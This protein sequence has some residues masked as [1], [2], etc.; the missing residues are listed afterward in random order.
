MAERGQSVRVLYDYDYTDSKGNKIS[1]KTGDECTLLKKSTEE[2]WSVLRKSEKKPIYVPANYVEALPKKSKDLPPKPAERPK[3][4]G[5]PPPTATKPKFQRP[6]IE[7]EALKMLDAALEG[8]VFDD[9]DLDAEI[10]KDDAGFTVIPPRHPGEDKPN[11]RPDHNDNEDPA[12]YDI[13]IPVVGGDDDDDINIPAPD[14]DDD[15]PPT[16]K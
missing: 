6:S 8:E 13:P 15:S 16:R 12:L 1:I 2:W 4:K 3:K 10:P 7:D 5:P 9:L 14:Y 11:I